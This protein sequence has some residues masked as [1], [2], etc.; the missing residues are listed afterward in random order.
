ME[1]E[2]VVLDKM[3]SL[4]KSPTNP[5]QG[6]VI[7]VSDT[8]GAIQDSIT[9]II[10]YCVLCSMFWTDAMITSVGKSWVFPLDG[11]DRYCH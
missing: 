6:I 9:C 2:G 1:I 3:N 5:N 8:L 4:N 10:G 7:T 11:D